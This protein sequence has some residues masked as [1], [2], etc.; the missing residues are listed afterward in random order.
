MLY[1]FIGEV[2][3]QNSTCFTEIVKS[4]KE[5]EYFDPTLNNITLYLNGNVYNVTG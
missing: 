1:G 5:L 3:G 2:I 4:L